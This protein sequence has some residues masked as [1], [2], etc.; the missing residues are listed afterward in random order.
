VLYAV[1]CGCRGTLTG[2]CARYSR[3]WGTISFEKY[4]YVYT[5]CTNLKSLIDNDVV[6]NGLQFIILSMDGKLS[7]QVVE[8]NPEI[9]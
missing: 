9:K 6:E 2:L 8:G 4:F 5:S 1:R 7:P 3:I